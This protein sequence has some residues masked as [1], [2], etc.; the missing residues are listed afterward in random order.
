ML[1]RLSTFHKAKYIQ[2]TFLPHWSCANKFYFEHDIIGS[3]ELRRWNKRKRKVKSA[4]LRNSNDRCAH[5]V[6]TNLP[7]VVTMKEFN[8]FWSNFG[9]KKK[10][11]HSTEADIKKPADSRYSTEWKSVFFNLHVKYYTILCKIWKLPTEFIYLNFIWCNSSRSANSIHITKYLYLYKFYFV[12]KSSC[13]RN[14]NKIKSSSNILFVLHT[15]LFSI[16]KNKCLL[17]SLVTT[18]IMQINSYECIMYTAL[19][20][21]MLIFAAYE[22]IKMQ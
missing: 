3:S 17:K 22:K 8:L 16:F 5:K 2:K 14:E 9:N 18:I 6:L 21:R 12:E 13:R 4:F 7:T 15:E 11:L 1:L 10:S 19:K 20:K